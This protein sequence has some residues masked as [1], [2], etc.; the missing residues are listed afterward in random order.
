MKPVEVE[1]IHKFIKLCSTHI[2]AQHSLRGSIFADGRYFNFSQFKFCGCTL[3]CQY[4][5]NVFRRS[6]FHSL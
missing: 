1:A 2:I 3:S 4:M 6:N 5:L